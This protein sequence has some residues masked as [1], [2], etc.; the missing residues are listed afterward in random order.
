MGDKLANAPV[1]LTAAQVRH[2]PVLA[3]NDYAAALQEQFRKIGFSDY[4]VRIQTGFAIDMSGPAGLQVKTENSHQHSY[5]NRAGS[6]GFVLENSRLYF[7]VTEYDVFDSF[8]DDFLKGLDLLHATVTLEYIDS[9]SMRLL[10]AIVPVDGE[11]LSLYLAKEL[12]GIGQ[13]LDEPTWQLTHSAAEATISTPEHRIVVRTLA[14]N[15]KL[16]VPPDLNI[17]GMKIMP[18]FS[19]IEGVHA[20]LDT[21]CLHESRSDFDVAKISSRLRLLKDDLRSTFQSAVTKHALG[22]W[23]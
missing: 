10:D 4:K 12:L 20:I 6:A 17:E 13:V 18:R 22:A 1:F 15:G 8:R 2:N 19:D 11:E 23:S 14:R 3:L 21:D 9:V 16:A 5:L 7:Q